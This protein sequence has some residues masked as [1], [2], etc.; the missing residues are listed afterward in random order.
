MTP[1]GRAGDQVVGQRL[2]RGHGVLAGSDPHAH[3]RPSDRQQHVGGG[4][5]ARGVDRQDRHGRLR[6]DPVGRRALPDRGDAL[7]HAGLGAQGGLVQVD[8]GTGP[9]TRPG[10]AT[11]PSSSCRAAS[12]RHSD[13]SASGNS[14]PNTPECCSPACVRTSTNTSTSPAQRRGERRDVDLP[15]RRVGDHDDVGGQQVGVLLEE[16]RERRRADLLLAL[17]EDGH[18]HRQPVRV[19]RLQDAQ[20]ADVRHDPGLVVGRATAVQPTVALDRLERLAVPV[21]QVPGGLDVVVGVEQ[22]RRGARRARGSGR[23]PPARRPRRRAPGRRASRASA[24]SVATISALRAT[25]GEVAPSRLTLGIRTRS[26]RSARMPGMAAATAARNWSVEG[27]VMAASCQPAPPVRQRPGRPA[28]PHDHS[29]QPP[30]AEPGRRPQP[31]E[32]LLDLDRGGLRTRCPPRRCRSRRPCSA[33][34]RP[35]WSPGRAGTPT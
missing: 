12:T 26:S 10:T 33:G 20:G 24:R 5:G 18:A 19:G 22:H 9:R 27:A 28:P 3:L 25:S 35:G 34:R 16:G 31:A 11:R 6:P 7:E 14:P 1:H 2:L 32:P 23:P 29:D 21:G 15:V 17:D 30:A 8:L 13:V 4:L